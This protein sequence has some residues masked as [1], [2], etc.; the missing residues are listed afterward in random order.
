MDEKVKYWIDIANYDL[1]T[2]KA[3][4]LTERYLY[5]GFMCH[6]VI[7]KLLKSY[8][9]FIYD[10]IPPY[11]HNLKLLTTKCGLDSILSEEQKFDQ[12]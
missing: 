3:M 10:D 7:E 1:D 5:V 8:Y 2:A 4:L 9:A 12:I 6:Q 11:T